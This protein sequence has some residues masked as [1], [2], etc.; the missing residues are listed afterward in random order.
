MEKK[1]ENITVIDNR[2]LFDAVAAYEEALL[3]EATAIGALAEQGADNEY[4]REIVRVGTMCADYESNY[5]TFKNL[6]FKKTI[7]SKRIL[8]YA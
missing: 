3:C 7:D 5:M 8:E 4:T 1:F 6:K 2:A